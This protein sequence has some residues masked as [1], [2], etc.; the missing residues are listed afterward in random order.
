MPMQNQKN[1]L[2]SYS[3]ILTILAVLMSLT[4]CMESVFR[5]VIPGSESDSGT[6]ISLGVILDLERYFFRCC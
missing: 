4:S 3:I 2:R 5:D 1:N 6:A